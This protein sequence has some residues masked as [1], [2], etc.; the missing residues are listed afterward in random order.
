MSGAARAAEIT[1]RWT[2]A[3]NNVDGSPLTDLAGAKVYYGLAS[4][5]YHA[6]IDVGMVTHYTVT[7]LT[8]GVTHYLN[9]TAYNR[10]GLESDFCSEVAEVA[11]SPQ[12]G[13]LDHFAWGPISSPQVAG[14]PFHATV[15]AQDTNHATVATFVGSVSLGA[16]GHGYAA[17]GTGTAVVNVPMRT[18]YDDARTEVIYVTSEVG[19]AGWITAL[20]LNVSTVPDQTLK[21]WTVRLKHTA[22]QKFTSGST[23][24]SNGWTIVYRQDATVTATGW[25]SFAFSTPFY[26]NAT[27]NLMV[28][29]SFNNTSHAG[30]GNCRYTTAS[31]KRRLSGNVNG[32]SYGD[33]LNWSGAAPARSLS[34][35]IPN[36][37]LQVGGPVGISPTHV[38]DFVRGTWSGSVTMGNPAAGVVLRADDGAGHSGSGPPFDVAVDP[39]TA[40]MDPVA[41]ATPSP[42]DSDGD[43]MADSSELLAGTDPYDPDSALTMN[44]AYRPTGEGETGIAVE[45]SSVTGVFYA[46]ERSTNLMAVP[47]F[48]HTV[49]H[50]PG[51]SPI[52]TYTDTTATGIGPYY[53]RVHAEPGSGLGQIP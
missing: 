21:N 43:G 45:W 41:E 31:G 15:T 12:S 50:V 5:N 22:L 32:T 44:G 23:W 20:A 34:R 29:F 9:G 38:V 46:V 26:Y 40:Q 10:A 24:E 35:A 49:S 52:T 37:R 13:L 11:Q 47:T 2:F 33:P 6:F 53:Y 14:V 8:A 1:V 28:D 30:A 39:L 36:I 4:S 16:S 48:M 19:Q 3:T 27:S 42:G 25:V 7:G 18:S 51:Q 17:I